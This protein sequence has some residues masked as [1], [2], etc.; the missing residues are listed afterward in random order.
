M[1]LLIVF[2]VKNSFYG[3]PGFSNWRSVQCFGKGSFYVFLLK[4]Q[5]CKV[6]RPYTYLSRSLLTLG[7][8]LR[9][10]VSVS[11]IG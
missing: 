10:L 7:S 11:S 1:L 2:N 4:I 9:T 3:P 8:E 6:V 5:E